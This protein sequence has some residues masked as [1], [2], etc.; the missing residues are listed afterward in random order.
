MRR[1]NGGI[2]GPDNVTTGG[3]FGTASGVFKLGEVTDLIRQNK[4]PT[5]GPPATVANS[6]RFNDGSTDSLSRSNGTPSSRRIFTFSGWYKRGVS[7]AGGN[8]QQL[9]SIYTDTS[10]R[11]DFRFQG[12]NIDFYNTGSLGRLTTNRK[13]TDFSSWYH[14]VIRVD[15]TQSTAADRFRLYINGVQET[16]FSTA[17]YP[18]EDADLGTNFSTMEIGDDSYSNSQYDGYM[19]EVIY[20]DGQSLAPTSFGETNSDSGIWVPKTITGLTFGNIGYYLKFTN[21]SALG[22]DFSGENNDFTVNNLTSVDQSTDTP[23]NNFCVQNS[24]ATSISGAP[25]FTSGN[26]TIGSGSGWKTTIGTFA[27]TSGKWYWEN[28]GG[29]SGA[30]TL[31]YGIASTAVI[32]AGGASSGLNNDATI[33]VNLPAYGYHGSSGSMYYSNTSGNSQGRSS[34]GTAYN[35][36]DLISVYLDLDNNKL[37]M[38]KND[39]LQVS[40]V[41]YDIQ[42]GYSYYPMT[43]P[44]DNTLNMNYGIGSF[45]TTAVSSAVADTHGFGAFEYSPNRGGAAVFDG[46]AKNFLALCTNN[47]NSI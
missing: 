17:T 27:L 46:E 5:A 29:G 36:G 4:W 39:A 22:E 20:C 14:V 44:Y 31:I 41:G 16:S 28:R 15:T 25:S 18:S 7:N 12:D 21:A 32:D 2:I 30:G 8:N 34:W 6:C 37:Y 33:G 42:A 45:G 26:L 3:A 10:N 47:L 11:M 24:N 9:F 23:N 38:A 19:A 43:V 35:P 13:F 1:S 40:G